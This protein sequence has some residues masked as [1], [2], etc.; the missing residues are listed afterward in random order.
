M[1]A[2]QSTTNYIDITPRAAA[3]NFVGRI[4]SG[5]FALSVTNA[6]SGG[7]FIVN[8]SGASALQAYRN[9]VAIA[10]S[11][12][13]SVAPPNAPITLLARS[14]AGGSPD[15]YSSDQIA[16]ASIGASLTD[17]EA[18]ALYAAINTYLTGIG[19]A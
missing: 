6:T 18:A 8:R 1:G 3:G 10:T 9:G 7:H 15:A 4:N 19:A 16:A 17:T 14:L 2:R 13:A 11:T 5:V 12:A